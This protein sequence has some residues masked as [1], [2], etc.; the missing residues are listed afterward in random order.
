MISLKKEIKEFSLE[1]DG[2]INI[3]KDEYDEILDSLV[4]H[5]LYDI[6]EFA[7]EADVYIWSDGTVSLCEYSYGYISS[8]IEDAHN[9]FAKLQGGVK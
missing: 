4:F 8:D 3:F 2:R 9:H 5:S 7:E 6:K 1:G